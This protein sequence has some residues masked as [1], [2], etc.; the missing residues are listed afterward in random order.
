MTLKTLLAWLTQTGT[1]MLTGWYIAGAPHCALSSTHC[2]TAND[3]R[4]LTVENK[5]LTARDRFFSFCTAN[6]TGKQGVTTSPCLKVLRHLQPVRHL[7]SHHHLP[8][9][10]D[11][12]N[13]QSP[14]L[15]GISAPH[16][17]PLCLSGWMETVN[18]S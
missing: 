13:G 11:K 4:E 17:C 14:R 2:H 3:S 15:V 6:K 16:C 1:V 10:I 9:V 5:D 8:R 18:I 7:S 12:M